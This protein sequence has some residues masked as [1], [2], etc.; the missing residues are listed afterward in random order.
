MRRTFLLASSA[1]LLGACS[2]DRPP[3]QDAGGATAQTATEADS[4]RVG[5]AAASTL[6][7]ELMG[8]L[9]AAIEEGGPAY[10]LDFCSEQA[11]PLT[12][13]VAADLGVGIKRTS[14]RIRN[15]ANAPDDADRAALE[16]FEAALAAGEPLPAEHVQRLD[17]E[18]R[19]YRPIVVAEFCT[20][21]HGLRDALDTDVRAALD[22][23][24]PDD[25]AT[26]FRAGDLRGVVRVSIPD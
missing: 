24:Y 10:A 6:T 20:T 7:S 19:Y 22:A 13:G 8:R 26:G 16:H 23:R 9:A 3:E 5:A 18:M 25:Q 1:L 14:S 15:P 2:G 4:T 17:G 21:C 12:A 11:L